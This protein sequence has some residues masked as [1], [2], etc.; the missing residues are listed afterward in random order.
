MDINISDLVKAK[1]MSLTS[2]EPP[3]D[4]DSSNEHFFIKEDA[5]DQRSD[6]EDEDTKDENENKPDLAHANIFAA[7]AALQTGQLTLSQVKWSYTIKIRCFFATNSFIHSSVAPIQIFLEQK[8]SECLFREYALWLK[9]SDFISHEL[10]AI[11]IQFCFPLL[12]IK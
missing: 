6:E 11:Q 5:K 7:L 3:P 1:A 2:E 10:F 9:Q 8:F 4:H 12:L